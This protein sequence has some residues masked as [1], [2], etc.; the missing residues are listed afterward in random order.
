[1]Y[2]SDTGCLLYPFNTTLF[3]VYWINIS[4]WKQTKPQ[5][6]YKLIYGFKYD[7]LQLTK[8]SG[9]MM[10]S[11]IAILEEVFLISVLEVYAFTAETKGF[12]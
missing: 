3:K 11:L 1:M 2:I 5:L 4:L 8:F 12:M 10:L 7:L 6:V 9:N